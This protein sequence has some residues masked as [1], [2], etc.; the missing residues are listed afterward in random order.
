VKQNVG[1]KIYMY[2]KLCELSSRLKKS[3]LLFEFY[4][5]WTRGSFCVLFVGRNV[6]FSGSSSGV[7]GKRGRNGVRIIN[8]FFL[9]K[10]NLVVGAHMSSST[11]VADALLG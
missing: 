8:V 9:D 7:N 11:F 10:E 6:C 3:L 4:G 1:S 2:S 5:W